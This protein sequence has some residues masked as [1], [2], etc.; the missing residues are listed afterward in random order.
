MI[1][2]MKSL[3]DQQNSAPP[4]L[5][6]SVEGAEFSVT[7]CCGNSEPW[8]K[9]TLPPTGSRA[10]RTPMT[11]PECSEGPSVVVPQGHSFPLLVGCSRESFEQML[12]HPQRGHPK[13]PSKHLTERKIWQDFPSI[14]GSMWFSIFPFLPS[15]PRCR[16]PNELKV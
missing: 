3:T 14:S 9:R 2:T 16:T 12:P 11:P 13:E 6:W 4:Y 15:H 8:G 10:S 5:S 1:I 7:V